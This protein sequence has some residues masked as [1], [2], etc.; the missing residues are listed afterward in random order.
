[1]YRHGTTGDETLEPALPG[2]NSYETTLLQQ[3]PILTT[4]GALR[5]GDDVIWAARVVAWRPP[6]SHNVRSE[7]IATTVMPSNN[8]LLASDDVAA[9]VSVFD[10]L[11]IEPLTADDAAAGL[12]PQLAVMRQLTIGPWRGVNSFVETE[13]D[14]SEPVGK[15]LDAWYAATLVGVALLSLA[16]NESSRT[17]AELAPAVSRVLV[18]GLGGGSIPTFIE[19]HAPGVIIHVVESSRPVAVAA[20]TLF[21]LDCIFEPAMAACSDDSTG[22]AWTSLPGT[23]AVSAANYAAVSATTTLGRRDGKR[24]GRRAAENSAPRLPMPAHSWA[25]GDVASN[26]ARTTTPCTVHIA[27][28]G[29]FVRD[30][31]AAG[32]VHFDAVLVDVYTAERFPDTLLAPEFFS[33]LRELVNA[34]GGVVVVNAGCSDDPRHSCALRLMRDAFADAGAP[35]VV[36]LTELAEFDDV[37]EAREYESAVIVGGAGA[38]CVDALLSAAAWDALLAKPS[39]AEQPAVERLR[40]L[41]FRLGEIKEAEHASRKAHYGDSA[42]HDQGT[43]ARLDWRQ[44]H[45]RVNVPLVV[46]KGG[47]GKDDAAW[48]IF[49]GGESDDSS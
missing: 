42:E 9:H 40:D 49:D 47:L 6:L 45:W 41:P 22:E 27:D 10:V 14:V 33:G 36:A 12:G 31:V 25:R 7:K 24:S 29:A 20:Q 26:A 4:P 46:V 35:A 32:N 30:A 21:G 23:S 1:M 44:V 39:K 16:A 5:D 17:K 8:M 43:A 11:T 18:L 3:L 48:G 38:T 15:T 13:L 19:R 37:R 2:G 34:A 28:A